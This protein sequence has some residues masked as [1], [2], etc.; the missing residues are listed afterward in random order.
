MKKIFLS[1]ILV[2]TA[3]GASSAGAQ[4]KFVG[5]V[6]GRTGHRALPDLARVEY[7]A[8]LSIADRNSITVSQMRAMNQEQLDQLYA[9]LPSGMIPEGDFRGVVLIKNEKAKE[10]AAK[11]MEKAVSKGFLGFFAKL[12]VGGLCRGKSELD[13]MGE[14]L[15]SGKRFY[16]KNQYGEVELRNAVD[17]GNI[18]IQTVLKKAGLTE[19]EAPM[20]RIAQ[21]KFA[22]GKSRYIMMPANVFCSLSLFDVR[23]ESIIIDYAYGDDFTPFIAPIDGLVGRNGSWVRDEIRMVRPG[24]YL[25]RA[26]VDRIFMLNFILESA[27]PVRQTAGL[28]DDFKKFFGR[29]KEAPKETQPSNPVNA[30]WDNQCWGTNSWQ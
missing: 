24:L 28:V 21:D 22:G 6:M 27:T 19:L 4:V 13:C 12:V 1:S 25:G 2:V 11:V 5:P 3:L 9:R 16:K 7:V 29:D 10:T 8:P 30:S 26:Y 15:W 14:L 17:W 23:K 18:A 20:S